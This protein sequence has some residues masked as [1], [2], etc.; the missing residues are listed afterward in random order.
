MLDNHLKENKLTEIITSLSIC[1]EMNIKKQNKFSDGNFLVLSLPNQVI[2]KLHT[3]NQ[4]S[5]LL[6]SG[7]SSKEDLEIS[8]W[9]TN[10]TT[11]PIFPN[12]SSVQVNIKLHT[13]NQLPS[14]LDYG[15][16][17]EEDLKIGIWKTTLTKLEFVSQ[18]S[19]ASVVLVSRIVRL[20]LLLG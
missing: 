4:L 8:I 12:I 5:S 9:K 14:W 17:N 20:T 3:E 10:S 1:D 15:D 2:I 13:D 7:Y 6:N 18:Y 11:F 19:G 16:S